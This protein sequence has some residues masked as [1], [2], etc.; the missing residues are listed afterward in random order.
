MWFL[1]IYS[2]KY[3]WVF[4][5][6]FLVFRESL[7][8]FVVLKVVILSFFCPT[9]YLV[10]M[11]ELDFIRCK[12]YSSQFIKKPDSILTETMTPK[13]CAVKVL[14]N[15]VKPHCTSSQGFLCSII[16]L[17]FVLLQALFQPFV[18]LIQVMVCREKQ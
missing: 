16:N 7:I 1:V 6:L 11:K 4:V 13:D 18:A 5:L 8:E 3:I 12:H 15:L 10:S 9:T 17:H 14:T 2:R